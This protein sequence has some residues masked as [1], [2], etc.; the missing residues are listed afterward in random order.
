MSIN[1]LADGKYLDVNQRF[2][3]RTGFRRE[4]I[5]GRLR[6]EVDLWLD[7]SEAARFT[8]LTKANKRV[9]NFEARLKAAN[10][11]QGFHLLSTEVIELAGLPCLLVTSD[12]ITERK[13][14]E[15]QLQQA[16]KLESIGR[17]AGGV[18]HDFNNLL[19]VINGYSDLLLRRMDPHDPNWHRIDQIRKAGDRAA[20]LTSQLL[21]FSRKQVSKPQTLDLNPLI[22]E[23]EPMLRRLLPESIETSFHLSDAPA[24]VKADPGQLNQVLINLAVN[25]RDAMPEGGSLLVQTVVVQLDER[26][27]GLH[28]GLV[29]GWYV[30]LAI[31]DS[32]VGMTE[33]VRQHVFEPFFTTKKKGAGTGLGPKWRPSTESSA[34]AA[35]GSGSIAS[36]DMDP[37]LKSTFRASRW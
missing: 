2:L 36:R 35:A 3:E 11:Q 18:A 23:T 30:L 14:L 13:Q 1:T 33:E 37:L 22:R 10:G 6:S 4:E 24:H 17:L 8:E 20:E 26:S 5:V 27:V 32:G 34:R 31:S 16:Q 15:E 9:R 12:E 25:A 7:A 28:S 29:P 19:T 21:A